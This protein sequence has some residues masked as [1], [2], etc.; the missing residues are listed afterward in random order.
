MKHKTT[1]TYPYPPAD[2]YRLTAP[3]GRILLSAGTEQ[4]CWA[5]LHQVQTTSV[6]GALRWQGYSMQP[7][8][9]EHMGQPVTADED[10]RIS[11]DGP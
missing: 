10:R 6:L 5:M 9:D 8:V 1:D 4:E 3:D 11:R 2:R 7:I